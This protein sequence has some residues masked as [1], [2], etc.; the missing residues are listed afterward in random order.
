MRGHMAKRV[1][2]WVR[3]GIAIGALSVLSACADLTELTGLGGAKNS[4]AGPDKGTDKG[5]DRGAANKS[6][7]TSATET[8]SDGG[9]LFAVF[10]TVSRPIGDP[11]P[12]APIARGAVMVKGPKGYC[13]D[14]RSLRNRADGGFAL[15]ASCRVM[16]GGKDGAAVIPAL[17]TL[18]VVK[19]EPG[20]KTP[21]VNT[22][23]E[24]FDPSQV[25]SKRRI[26]GVSMV[27]L[28][29]FEAQ[30]I[31]KADP[32]HWRG[33]MALNGHLISMAVYGPKDGSAAA[34]AGRAL[35][36]ELAQSLRSASPQ[37]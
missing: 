22:L 29:A 20:T 25:L 15:L 18:S 13:V 37:P 7:G 12:Q 14:A 11:I 1:N 16:T 35:L 3:I 31:K 26:S 10:S 23:A 24:L 2:T 9:G 33:V 6:A 5:T 8:K 32:K 17:M 34:S 21:D 30:P 27:Q 36:V 4:S 28:G 19:A